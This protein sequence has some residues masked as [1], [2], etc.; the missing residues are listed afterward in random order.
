MKSDLVFLKQI[1]DFVDEIVGYVNGV[2]FEEFGKSGLLQDA[3]VEKL[4]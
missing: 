3:V 1:K 4:N 2:S